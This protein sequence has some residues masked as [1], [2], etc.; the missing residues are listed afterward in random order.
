MHESERS[1]LEP[2]DRPCERCGYAK[3]RLVFDPLSRLILCEDCAET[4]R[5]QEPWRHLHQVEA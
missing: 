1:A 4:V 5:E 3:P 2:P